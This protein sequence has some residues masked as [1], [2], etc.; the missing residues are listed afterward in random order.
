MR[1]PL[2]DLDQ[3]IKFTITFILFVKLIFSPYYCQFFLVL[4]SQ[5]DIF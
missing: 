5:F 2:E 3:N 4:I 1:M